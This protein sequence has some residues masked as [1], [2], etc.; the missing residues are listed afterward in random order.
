MLGPI[1]GEVGKCLGG[2]GV[3]IACLALGQ[4][5]LQR[6]LCQTLRRSIRPAQQEVLEDFRCFT[7]EFTKIMSLCLFEMGVLSNPGIAKRLNYFAIAVGGL[8]VVLQLKPGL[9]GKIEGLGTSLIIDT[10]G[11]GGSARGPHS[12][13]QHSCRGTS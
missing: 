10:T 8:V 1:D 6:S 13:G 2:L 11:R 7:I 9:G 12:D 5:E 4:A 3:L